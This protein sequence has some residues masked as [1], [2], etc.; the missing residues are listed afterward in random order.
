MEHPLLGDISNL[1]IEELQ[2]KISEINK[3][4][5]FAYRS[6]NQALVNQL[7][8]VLESY[9]IEY[10]R[11]MDKLMPKGGDDKYGDKIDIS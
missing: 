5:S 7:N 4:L 9:N 8:M 6:G 3:R 2:N 10:A 11:K 1:K